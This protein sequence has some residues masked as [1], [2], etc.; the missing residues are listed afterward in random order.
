MFKIKKQLS[1]FDLSSGEINSLLIESSFIQFNDLNKD[2]DMSIMELANH[3]FDSQVKKDNIVEENVNATESVDIANNCIDVADNCVE[4]ANK[5]AVTNVIYNNIEEES[6]SA[7]DITFYNECETKDTSVLSMYFQEIGKTNNKPPVNRD[8]V[9]AYLDRIDA[10]DQEAYTEF[11]NKNLRLVI[12]VAKKF[13]NS[14]PTLN[15]EDLI[16]E[17]NLGVMEAIKKYDR[18]KETSFAT[19]ANQWIEAKIKRYKENN[20][21][22]IR[23]PSHRVQKINTIKKVKEKLISEG[24]EPTV[25]NIVDITGFSEKVVRNTLNSELSFISINQDIGDEKKQSFETIIQTDELLLE[26]T[27]CNNLEQEELKCTFSDLL[28]DLSDEERSVIQLKIMQN[29]KLSLVSE[30]LSIST[31]EVTNIEKRALR[32]LKKKGHL[33]A[34]FI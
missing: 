27:V 1:F 11:I 23:I 2:I 6:I 26:D 13:H 25:E 14:N 18:T 12:S 5:E 9:N 32:K 21:Y 7:K 22:S 16:Q 17:G 28:N 10:G 29:K 33:L 15:L 20:G 4:V 31:T 19:Y 24:I 8:E 3:C 34:R 30:M